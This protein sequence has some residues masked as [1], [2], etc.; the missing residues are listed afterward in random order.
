M[1]P[2]AQILRAVGRDSVTD[3]VSGL[4]A[5][6]AFF[7]ALGF[8]PRLMVVAGLIGWIDRLT[9][10]HVAAMAESAKDGP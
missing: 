7:G 5:E 9:G 6:M 10:V 2:I 3:R 8:F 1:R 4:A